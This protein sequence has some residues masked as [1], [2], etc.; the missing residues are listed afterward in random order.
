[1][2]EDVVTT[3]RDDDSD[4]DAET[5]GNATESAAAK[6]RKAAQEEEEDKSY[7]CATEKRD[8]KP[9]QLPDDTLTDYAGADEEDRIIKREKRTT[10][11][12][13]RLRL[14]FEA[15]E[16]KRK[17]FKA[18]LEKKYAKY[19]YLVPQ[20]RELKMNVCALCEE[21]VD[22]LP[23]LY[24]HQEREHGISRYQGYAL[25][26]NIKHGIYTAFDHVLFHQDKDAFTCPE[27][28]KKCR[29]KY[30]LK[31]HSVVHKPEEQKNHH[32]SKCGKGFNE[33]NCL[34]KHEKKHRIYKFDC[35]E[36]KES[37]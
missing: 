12:Q 35:D 1:M 8:R 18:S 19:A 32:C 30:N 7:I 16:E 9:R 21:V 5:Y 2:C 28:G 22:T 13:R 23:G 4:S 33:R 11:S 36:C 26:C 24:C 14:P 20:M 10:S 31:K 15:Q 34:V 17:L 6:R 37:K 27:C 3:F 29:S 25:C